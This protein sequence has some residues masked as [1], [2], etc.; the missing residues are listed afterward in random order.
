MF[1]DVAFAQAPFASLGGNT[2]ALSVSES[3]VADAVTDVITSRGGLISESSVATAVFAN[4][5]N[6]FQA[7]VATSAVAT[8][9]QTAA[10]AVLAS[11][12]EN[13]TGSDEYS[14]AAEMYAGVAESSA[15]TA[16]FSATKTVL[17]AISELVAALAVQDGGRIFAVAVSESAAGA[18]TQTIQVAFTGTVSE[19]AAATASTS[20]SATINARPDG[21]QLYVRIGDTLVWAVIDDTQTPNWQNINDTQSPGWKNLPS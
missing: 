18:A 10:I 9:A 3:A 2:Y 5:G 4:S 17:A 12:A 20:A 7:T 13:A 16:S 14:N 1:G 15:A 21:V 11:L 19:L 6:F 8:D